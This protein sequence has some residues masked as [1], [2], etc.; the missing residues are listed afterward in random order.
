MTYSELQVT[1]H[2][3]FLRGASSPEDL[4]RQAALLGLPALGIVDRN[5][6]GGVV[7]ALV[8]AEQFSALG[9]PIRMI[10]GC[11]LDLV[12]GS[13]VL[14]WPEDRAA[15]SRLT[16]LLTLGK[17]RADAQKGEK[18]QCFLHW[19][20]LADA[21]QGLVG[22]LVPGL[23]DTG[24]PVS[25]RWMA[26]IFGASGH[27]C[28]TQHRRPGDALRLHELNLAAERFG[29]TP[30]ATGD[31][32]YDTPD[33]RMLQDVVTAIREKC[34]I[35]ELGFRRERNADRHLKSP[36]E[37]ARRFRDYPQALAASEAI[38]ERCTFSLRD[39]KHQYPEEEVID[40]RTAQE[41][42]AALAWNGLKQKFAGK[43]SQAHQDLL[44]H[45][46]G[47]VEQMDYAPYF[48]TVNSIVQF[49]LS[50]QI[51][52]QGRGSAANSVICFA[53]GITS[54]DPIVHQLLFERFISTERKEPPDIDVD[55]EHERREEVIQWI[56][57]SYGRDH[58]ALTAVVIR[59]RSRSAL[60]EVGKAMGLPEDMTAALSSQVWG[61]SNDVDDKHADA[62]NLDRSD[63]RLALTLELARQLVN[64][65]RH[66]SQHPG[67]F[68]LTRDKLHD[69]I[70]VEPAAMAE[71]H[72]VEWEKLDIEEL[73]FM[74]VD[75]LGLGM[76]GCMR[77]TFDLLAEH[78]RTY[79]TLASPKMQEEDPLTF[80]MIQQADTL[81]VFQIES[82]AQMSM[83][84]RM[85]PVCFYDI[86][87]QVAIVRPGPIQG[88]MVHPYLK[89]RQNPELVDY[90]SPKLKAVLKKTLGVPLFQEQ[91]MQVAIVGA[92]FTPSEADR[93]RRAMATFKSS[94]DI[95]EF[96][97]KLIEGMRRNGINETFAAQMVEQIKGFS[98]Y[99]FPESHA[100]SF[101]KIAYASSW[102][103]CHH[104]DVFCTA[105]LN[106]QP[107]G[108]YA[109]AQ[110]IRDACAHGV[111]AR[112][113]CINDSDWDTRMVPEGPN[114]R[115]QDPRFCGTEADWKSLQ[116]IRL[117]MRIVQGLAQEDARKVLEA[118]AEA[119]F[120]SIEDI[121]RRSRVKP[122]AL[123]RLARADA[124][125]ALGLNRRQALWAI[126]GLSQAPLDLFAAADAREGATVA[127]VVEP[128]VALLPLSAGREVVEDYRATQLSLRAH[129]LT[130]LR[131]RLAA[132][133]IAQCADLL[134]MK[135]GQ[136]VEV[137]GLILVRQRP[138]SAKGVVFVTL[139]DETGI[140]NAVLWAD[141]FEA[142][143][144]TVMSATMLAIKG[145]VQREG[146]V[147]HLVAEQITDLTPWLREVGELELPR[148]TMPGDGATHGGEIDPRDR[149]KLPRQR[150][151]ESWPPRRSLKTPDLIP[152]RS[153][154]FH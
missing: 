3:S 122:A 53:L 30:L 55:F 41:A 88:N 21:A 135:D 80:K 70:P 104:P 1:T 61:W 40:G 107:M 32:L 43:P 49:A 98:N 154:D 5:S 7:R 102:M 6:V 130:F 121:W 8:A 42:L 22:A 113:V 153:R 73:G 26:D 91:A 112:A 84:P 36:A 120:T 81:G 66:L 52:C 132:R 15:W 127:E 25:L 148:M 50:Q 133:R 31:V 94:G 11:R 37:M 63:P 39:L 90:P 86:A 134:N 92:D 78:K 59:F 10:A 45:E 65:P 123:E 138:G 115:E 18:G 68:V 143:R 75:I 4:F 96:G 27:L 60:R 13:S 20:D 97:P 77:R 74:K 128:Q 48:L 72:V 106:A 34:T 150:A 69:L 146:I 35:D 12:D 24:D 110:L 17:S 136:R 95:G 54:I 57:D 56:Y 71:R 46:L 116:P 62:L 82:R 85:K 131:D 23:A 105:L 129:P 108:F 118:R 125:Q 33:R 44:R 119:P 145:K 109:P 99:G 87:I 93:L 114:P 58:A 9:V 83:L 29:L 64:T 79:L 76:L 19:D 126:K 100:A 16:R 152:V 51:L 67:G 14:V 149:L 111:E 38:A 103:K 139:E 151:L 140:A 117:G 124:F 89:R 142:N 101:A 137:A 47:L 141:R 2:F 144:R 28:L 147:I